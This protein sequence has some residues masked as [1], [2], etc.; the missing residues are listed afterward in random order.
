MFNESAQRYT[1]GE[2]LA[3]SLTH[4]L[5]IVLS[6]CGAIALLFAARASAAPHA[7]AS[8][9]IYALTLLLLYTASTLYHSRAWPDAKT[10]LQ[11]LDHI[12]IFLLI[13]GTY[14]PFVLI[15]LRGAWGWSLFAITWT[16][17]LLG[18]IFELTTLRRFRRVQ[19][20]LYIAMGWIGLVAIGPLVA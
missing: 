16:L 19:I 12:A 15:T 4:A 1:A 3:N 14:T 5:G 6:L 13:A 9:A 8:C 7:L 2:E 18:V 20:A 11:A 17:A 10:L